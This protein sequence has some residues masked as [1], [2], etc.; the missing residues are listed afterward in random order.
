MNIR[1]H[2]ALAVCLLLASVTFA[3][4]W[5]ALSNGFVNYDNQD[6]VTENYQ[7]RRG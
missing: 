2:A 1:R 7:V 3:A 6:Y 5:P 4:Y